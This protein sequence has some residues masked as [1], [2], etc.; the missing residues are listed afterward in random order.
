MT[1]RGSLQV[2]GNVHVTAGVGH[3][4]IIWTFDNDANQALC[5][6]SGQKGKDQ[7]SERIDHDVIDKSCMI[8][9]THA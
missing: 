4:F 7:G 9:L 2:G 8:S 3:V 6:N 1:D 5:I